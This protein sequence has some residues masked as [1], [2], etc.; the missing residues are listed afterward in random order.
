M[1]VEHTN[2]SYALVAS[3][4]GFFTNGFVLPNVYMCHVP[5]EKLHQKCN[6]ETNN[7]T[8]TNKLKQTNQGKYAVPLN[9]NTYTIF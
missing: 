6:N 7:Q 9:K 4:L 5:C 2:Q 1:I 8:Q 3:I